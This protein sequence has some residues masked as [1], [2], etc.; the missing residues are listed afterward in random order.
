M[1][2]VYTQIVVK[3][4]TRICCSNVKP[5]ANNAL[6]IAHQKSA[7]DTTYLY[8]IVSFQFSGSPHFTV[9]HLSFNT[10][11]RS[12]W[13]CAL[14]RLP[15]YHSTLVDINFEL[16]AGDVMAMMYTSG[17]KEKKF[18]SQNANPNTYLIASWHS[19]I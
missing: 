13:D 6:I 4:I 10:D 18:T 2:Y 9:S 5:A 14:L 1:H 7:A 16:H 11:L 15:R 19:R 3:L 17:K 12:S 8:E